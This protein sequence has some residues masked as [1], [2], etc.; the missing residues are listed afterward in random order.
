[1]GCDFG[2]FNSQFS[3]RKIT[4]QLQIEPFFKDTCKK[5][6]TNIKL[7]PLSETVLIFKTEKGCLQSSQTY[8]FHSRQ[9]SCDMFIDVVGVEFNPFDRSV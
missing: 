2:H 8:R 1:M 5:L 4:V 6:F 9:I 3:L 7:N